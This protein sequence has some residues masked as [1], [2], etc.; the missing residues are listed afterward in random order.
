[1]HFFCIL[2]FD[3][4]HAYEELM[5]WGNSLGMLALQTE[6]LSEKIR[7]SASK[8]IIHCDWNQGCQMVYVFSNQKIKFG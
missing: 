6:F 4:G 1:L 7:F 8:E 3:E 5:L 2:F